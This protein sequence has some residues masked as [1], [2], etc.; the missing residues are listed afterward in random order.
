MIMRKIEIS[1][2]ANVNARETYVLQI[3]AFNS[4]DE[5]FN[6][7]F[8]FKPNKETLLGDVNGDGEITA[9]D[10]TILQNILLVRQHLMT[11]H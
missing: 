6:V 4:S 2:S 1:V 10:A 11:K 5:A 3:G 8:N 9:V 7:T